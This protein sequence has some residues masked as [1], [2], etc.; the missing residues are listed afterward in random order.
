MTIRSGEINSNDGAFEQFDTGNNHHGGG[1]RAQGIVRI[2]DVTIEGNRTYLSG[3]GADDERSGG[4]FYLD[5]NAW[6][7]ISD[8]D[9]TGN[10]AAGHGGGIYSTGA[11]FATNLDVVGN[12]IVSER[13]TGGGI[14]NS[15]TGRIDWTGGEISGNTATEYGG[16]LH[17]RDNGQATLTNVTITGNF[18]KHPTSGNSQGG[19]IYQEG[20]NALLTLDNVQVTGNVAQGRGAGIYNNNGK[21]VATNS[22]ISNNVAAEDNEGGNDIDDRQG[23]GIWN[24]GR[25]CWNSATSGSKTTP[26]APA[27]GST[28]ATPATSEWS[29]AASAETGPWTRTRTITGA[30]STTPTKPSF[31]S[32][33]S[34]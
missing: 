13:Q 24:S 10:E 3:P 14:W 19:G 2:E 26:A 30:A 25:A 9:V 17:N 5:G 29:A 27:A 33:V 16:G 21:I 11:I 7:T 31:C 34:T 15:G 6:L 28:T 20:G 1:F 12:T 8:S 32:T 23:G 18:T 4:G 22:I